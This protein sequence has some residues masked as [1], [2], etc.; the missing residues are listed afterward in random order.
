MKH[1][2]RILLVLAM[3]T[4]VFAPVLNAEQEADKG[5]CSSMKCSGC[6]H[7]EVDKKDAT[8]K[9]EHKGKTYTFCCEKCMEAFKKDPEKFAQCCDTKETYVCEAK[10]CDGKADQAGKCPKCGME[11]KKVEKHAACCDK[12]KTCTHKHEKCEKKCTEKK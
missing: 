3:I 7:A 1:L 8:F 9:V 4:L 6:K 12:A 5:Q 10:G 11:L 2:T